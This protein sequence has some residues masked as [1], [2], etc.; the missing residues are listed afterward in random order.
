MKK[1]MKTLRKQ[2][3]FTLIELMVTMAMIGF[4]ASIILIAL[5]NT[6]LKARDAKRVTD[7]KSIIK[8]FELYLNDNGVYPQ[9]GTAGTE[10]DLS[11]AMANANPAPLVPGYVSQVPTDPALAAQNHPYR[12]VTDAEGRN[13]GLGIYFEGDGVY[14]KYR[15]AGGLV[16]WFS[17][18]PDCVR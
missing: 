17:S 7:A 3:A 10:Y 4:L 2:K 6:R 13:F 1:T 8:S 12:Y 16:T 5:G 11:T 14:C 15:S 18:A 9:Y